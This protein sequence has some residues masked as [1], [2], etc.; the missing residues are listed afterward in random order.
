M[1]S[2]P[3]YTKFKSWQMAIAQYIK[4]DLI[5]NQA[6]SASLSTRSFALKF[7]EK[8]S[9]NFH[10]IS[11]RPITAIS[12]QTFASNRQKDLVAFFQFESSNRLKAKIRPSGLALHI[13]VKR[14]PHHLP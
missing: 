6:S 3:H 13:P 2:S 14:K 9:H 5:F 10:S 4:S 12:N 11:S 1:S 7:T 8:Q